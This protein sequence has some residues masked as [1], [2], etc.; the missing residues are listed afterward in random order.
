MVQAGTTL[1]VE[2]GVT[3]DFGTY[4]LE[5]NGVLKAQGTDS[6]KIL[7]TS[8]QKWITSTQMIDIA[9]SN[10]DSISDQTI[11]ENAIF[12]TTSLKI[13]ACSPT[14]SKN[15][16]TNL[17]ADAITVTSGS[18]TIDGNTITCLDAGGINAAGSATLTN[19]IISCGVYYAIHASGAVYV[20]GNKITGTWIVASIEGHVNFERNMITGGSQGL[21]SSTVGNIKYNYITGCSYYGITGSGTIQSNTITGNKVGIQGPNTNVPI[22]QNNIFD[23]TANSIVLASTQNVDATNNWWG[24]TDSQTINQTIYDSKNDFTVGTV[25]YIPFLTQSSSSA[26]TAESFNFTPAPTSSQTT[27]QPTSQAAGNSSITTTPPS[28]RSGQSGAADLFDLKTINVFVIVAIVVVVL[29]VIILG[30]YL[31]KGFKNQN[32]EV[33][34]TT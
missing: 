1:T 18:P 32:R 13:E 21:V 2:P 31:D 28:S 3:V 27:A 17:K 4:F 26:P 22:T 9:S 14:I 19:N 10:N 16:F 8:R 15:V 34:G 30:V 23:N 7:F 33:G 12:N 20:A 11:I 29:T 25:T 5:V 6:D 24:T